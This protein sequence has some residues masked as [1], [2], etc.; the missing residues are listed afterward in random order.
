MCRCGSR[1]R[2]HGKLTGLLTVC[3]ASGRETPASSSGSEDKRG[4]RSGTWPA[5]IRSRRLP[6]EP[7]TP[8]GTATPTPDIIVDHDGGITRIAIT[9]PERRNALAVDTVQALSRVIEEADADPNTRVVVV[10]GAGRGG[11]P[12][13]RTAPRSSPTGHW[14]RPRS[15]ARFER[16]GRIEFVRYRGLRRGVTA[17]M[18]RRKPSFR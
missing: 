11:A 16:N 8:A 14:V 1:A 10:T 9:R 7:Q 13:A 18:G 2:A 17:V 15:T 3:E 12:P 6:L 4:P 5:R